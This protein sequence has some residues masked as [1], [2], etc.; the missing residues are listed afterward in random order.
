MSA[1][2]NLFGTRDRLYGRQFFHCACGME[3]EWQWGETGG[4]AQAVASVKLGS[5]TCH[6]LPALGPIPNR[7]RG[8]P[9]PWPRG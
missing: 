7:P 6:L 3:G 9:D 8:G 1:V 5:L 4:G 2:P